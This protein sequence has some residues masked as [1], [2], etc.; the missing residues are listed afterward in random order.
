VKT[1][2]SQRK[3]KDGQGNEEEAHEETDEEAYEKK[4][5]GRKK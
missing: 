1:Y 3:R 2:V 4:V 5:M